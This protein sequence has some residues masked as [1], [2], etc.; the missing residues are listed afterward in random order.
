MNQLNKKKKIQTALLQLSTPA[1]S[2]K[3]F[4]FNKGT[5]CPFKSS[6]SVNFSPP[7]VNESFCSLLLLILIKQ[8]KLILH[9]VVE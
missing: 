2:P 7:V 1:V 4:I 3:I 6:I 5:L 8:I 9:F